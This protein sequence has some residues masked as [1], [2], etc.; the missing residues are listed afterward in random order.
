MSTGAIIGL[1]VTA[2]FG[3]GG[4]V[5]LLKFRGENTKVI[6]SAAGEMVLVQGNVVA[7]LRAEMAELRQR[8]DALEA[9]AEEA[10]KVRGELDELRGY[11][12]EVKLERDEARGEARRLRIERDELRAEVGELAARVAAVEADNA[13]L[14]QHIEE[15][16]LAG[17]HRAGDPPLSDTEAPA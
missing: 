7:L 2:L 3:G 8:C 9:E 10:R 13:E 14:R 15:H 11:H 1:V 4:I 5:A 6:V 17:G 12:E 16:H